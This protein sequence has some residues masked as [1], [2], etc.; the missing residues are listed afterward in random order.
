MARYDSQQ[1]ARDESVARR[2]DQYQLNLDLMRRWAKEGA[3]L[4]R[5]VKLIEE[6]RSPL[7]LPPPSLS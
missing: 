2:V 6:G 4:D 1:T 3:P 7:D 5:F